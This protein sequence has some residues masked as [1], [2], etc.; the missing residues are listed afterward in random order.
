MKVNQVREKWKMQEKEK[1]SE[2][3][4]FFKKNYLHYSAVHARNTSKII[5]QKQKKYQLIKE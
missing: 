4:K 2:K 5:T 3:R 1:K